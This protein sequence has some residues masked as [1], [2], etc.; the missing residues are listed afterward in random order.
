MY[1]ND[2]FKSAEVD[3][4]TKVVMCCKVVLTEPAL[5]HGDCHIVLRLMLAQMVIFRPVLKGCH[6][7]ATFWNSRGNMIVFI[8]SIFS[9]FSVRWWFRPIQQGSKTWQPTCH[10]VWK[11]STWWL[12]GASETCWGPAL[13]DTAKDNEEKAGH[14]SKCQSMSGIEYMEVHG[15]FGWTSLHFPQESTEHI[16]DHAIQTWRLY[17]QLKLSNAFSDEESRSG[18]AAMQSQ[19]QGSPGKAYKGYKYIYIWAINSYS[20]K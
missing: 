14:C 20:D 6:A 17:L 1:C 11:Y 15:S 8:S 10:A 5:Q 12:D 3:Q 7:H 18:N 9:K 19:V 4:T 13:I 2:S 16:P